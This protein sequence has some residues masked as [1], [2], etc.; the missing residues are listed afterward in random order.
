MTKEMPQAV[1]IIPEKEMI[2][3]LAKLKE[4]N[5]KHYRAIY[6]LAATGFRASELLNLKFEDIDLR[7]NL[8]ALKNSKCES[9]DYFS[10]YPA[11]REFIINE[12]RERE[13]KV[14][15]F[16]NRH[17]LK[18]FERFLKNEG[19][20]HYTLHALRKTFISRIINSGVPIQDVMKIVRLRIDNCFKNLELIRK[21]NL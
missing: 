13:R 12:F 2:Q 16:K 15:D 3:I 14:F 7:K 1:G 11:L 8:I 17:S 10:I 6:F 19:F 4:K 5:R 20:N 21:N 9:I 18:F